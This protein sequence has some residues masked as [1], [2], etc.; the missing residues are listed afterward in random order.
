M[1]TKFIPIIIMLVAGLVASLLTWFNE[2]EVSDSL[3]IILIVLVVFYLL[4]LI[5]KAVFDRALRVEKL[6]DESEIEEKSENE[7]KTEEEE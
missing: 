6:E 4:G 2:Y 7:E 5:V 1:K 3:L